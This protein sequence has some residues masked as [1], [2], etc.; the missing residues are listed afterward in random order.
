MP[1]GRRARCCKH[2]RFWVDTRTSMEAGLLPL[3]QHCSPGLS[4]GLRDGELPL[5]ST[6]TAGCLAPLP[7]AVA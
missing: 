6:V 2:R 1:P 7:C 4:L 5:T 3:A